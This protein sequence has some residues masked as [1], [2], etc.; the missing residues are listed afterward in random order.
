LKRAGTNL[1]TNASG[2]R[3][4]NVLAIKYIL[5]KLE[6]GQLG[7][8]DERRTEDTEQYPLRLHLRLRS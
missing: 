4:A 5:P 3:A 6:A 7:G 2:Q 1:F 8:R